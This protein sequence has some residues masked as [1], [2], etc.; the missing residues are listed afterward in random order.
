VWFFP[1][2]ELCEFW[3]DMK[4]IFGGHNSPKKVLCGKFSFRFF[5]E[6]FL[7][8]FFFFFF[9]KI[10]RK[11]REKNFHGFFGKNYKNPERRNPGQNLN[12]F[13]PVL[14]IWNHQTQ[15]SEFLRLQKCLIHP[16]KYL[17]SFF[18]S[19]TEELKTGKILY[20][21]ISELFFKE[22][23]VIFIF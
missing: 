19:L 12:D 10:E 8:H 18:L 9:L 11:E 17:V 15:L 4:N 21:K 20:K 1:S 6:K 5:L 23:F 14:F 7:F 22:K 3:R 13:D 2:F 16:E